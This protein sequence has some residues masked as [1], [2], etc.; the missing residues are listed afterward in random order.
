MRIEGINLADDFWSDDWDHNPPITD[1]A[2]A[3]AERVLGVK[4]PRE[5]VALLRIQN[6]GYLK[7]FVYPTHRPTSWAQDHVLLRELS[8]IG[9]SAAPSGLHNIYNTV[10]MTAEWGL[11]PKQ[12]LLSGDGHW[13]ISLDYRTGAE[14]SVAWID[15]EVG[16][17]IQLA[18]SFGAF[19]NGLLPLEAID[20]ETCTL[21]NYGA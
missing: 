14:P 10:Y 18:P 4:L 8:G 2:V 5:L 12:V 15:V 13:W 3:D 19:L 7:G 20:E 17:D 11:P 6:G 1:E 9:S 16:E 21:K